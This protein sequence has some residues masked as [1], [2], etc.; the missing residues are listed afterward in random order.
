MP[1]EIGG[2]WFKTSPVKHRENL[3]QKICQTEW[4]MS[5][6]PVREQAE[7]GDHSPRSIRPGRSM[8][9]FLKNN[10]KHKDLGGM[11]IRWRP[12]WQVHGIKLK[13][14]YC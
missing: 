6:I 11:T 14:W 7:G 1:L 10:P 12:S 2:L 13:H 3:S 4:Y 9:H 8:R 5:V